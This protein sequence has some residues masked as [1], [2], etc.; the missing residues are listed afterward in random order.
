MIGVSKPGITDAA[1]CIRQWSASLIPKMD[2]LFTSYLYE[3]KRIDIIEIKESG[4][5]PVCSSSGLYKIRRGDGNTGI[6]PALL[7][8]MIVGYESFK[9]ALINECAVN[10]PL[11]KRINELITENTPYIHLGELSYSAIDA[12]LSNGTLSSFFDIPKLVGIKQQCIQIN[13]LLLV[14]VI[15]NPDLPDQKSIIN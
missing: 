1:S 7:R 6:D 13:K 12:I 15:E 5:K 10:I 2:A 3:G 9:V 8:Q 4:Q 14:A 11:L